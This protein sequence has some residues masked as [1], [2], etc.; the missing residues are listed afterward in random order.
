MGNS[1]LLLDEWYL[2]LV[3]L[4]QIMKEPSL[5]ADAKVPCYLLNDRQLT[6]KMSLSC[7]VLGS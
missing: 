3:S 2:D 1:D 5:P 6:V 4:F 7:F